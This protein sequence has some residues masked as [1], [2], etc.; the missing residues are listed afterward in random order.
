MNGLISKQKLQHSLRKGQPNILLSQDNFCLYV[1]SSVII[2]STQATF[3][4]MSVQMFILAMTGRSM[5]FVKGMAG[6]L[7]SEFREG[8]L[9]KVKIELRHERGKHRGQICWTWGRARSK[10]QSNNQQALLARVSKARRCA[11]PWK[12]QTLQAQKHY[13]F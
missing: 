11:K 6:Y 4:G 10:A 2:N 12:T 5:I 9:G 3:R 7:L 8:F 13:E 1:L